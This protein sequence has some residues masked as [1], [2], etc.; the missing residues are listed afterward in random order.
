MIALDNDRMLS[1]IVYVPKEMPDIL[2]RQEIL[3]GQPVSL[4]YHAIKKEMYRLKG[5]S[6]LIWSLIDGKR[7]VSMIVKEV[8]DITGETN[9]ELVIKDVVKCIVKAGRIDLIKFAY[10]L[11]TQES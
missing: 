6:S 8:L 2:Y 3:D 5:N 1:E 11:K 7:T 9:E 4:I 10:K